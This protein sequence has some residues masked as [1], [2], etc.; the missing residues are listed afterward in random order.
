MEVFF[1]DVF[2][3]FY[4]AGLSYCPVPYRDVQ[5][6]VVVP[7]S[8]SLSRRGEEPRGGQRWPRGAPPASCA[9]SMAHAL[10]SAAFVPFTRQTPCDRRFRLDFCSLSWEN[11]KIL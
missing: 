2:V 10:R 5:W 6:V 1:S 8:S 11:L 4:S 9:S 7:A 3:P